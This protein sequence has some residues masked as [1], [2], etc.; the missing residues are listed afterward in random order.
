MLKQ[1]ATN[2]FYEILVD[3]EQNLLFLELR[4]FWG[5]RTNVPEYLNDCKKAATYLQ[6]G[7]NALVDL[8]K[9]KTISED[10]VAL[11]QEVQ[12]F[13]GGYGLNK[14]A[15]IHR[16]DPIVQYQFSHLARSTGVNKQIQ[17]FT[18]RNAAMAWLIQSDTKTGF[19][20]SLRG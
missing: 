18:D 20:D 1:I 13:F 19:F 11:H 5:S 8:T 3:S 7:F 15:E 4:G 10:A 14:A 12:K 17:K 9:T 2:N 6:P 16:D